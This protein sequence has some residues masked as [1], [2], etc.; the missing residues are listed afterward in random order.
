[1]KHAEWDRGDGSQR[2]PQIHLLVRW[3]QSEASDHRVENES[4]DP[5]SE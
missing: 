2:F 1:M 4:V 5:V 3:L